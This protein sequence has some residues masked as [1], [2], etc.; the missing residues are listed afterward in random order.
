M[1]P[2]RP[3]M[4]NPSLER[5]YTAIWQS[6][7]PHEREWIDEI[8]GPFLN[9]QLTDGKHELVLDN[10]ILFEAFV[11]CHDLAYYERFR[12]KN[13]FLV[14]F[15]DE[16]FEGRYQEI[17]R[18]F[19][20]VF[21]CFWANVF[22]PKYVMQ[23]P[24]GY[25][26]G[27]SRRKR[28]IE[29]ATRRKYLWS[30]VGQLGKSSRP[31]MAK[32]LLVVEPHFLLATDQAPRRVFCHLDGKQRRLAPSECSEILLQSTFAPCPMGNV[33]LECYR[34]Y[35]ALE[36]GSIPIVEKR[37][38]LDYFREL[39]GEHP[40]PTVRSWRE[41]SD[42]I[43]RLLRSPAQ[44]DALQKRCL[45]WWDRYKWEY[46]E[47]VGEFLALRTAD[48]VPVSEPIMA[49]TY[50]MPGWRVIQLLRHHDAKAFARRVEKHVSR[51]FR[52]GE[53][54]VANRPGM[55]LD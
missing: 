20:G 10:A 40:V 24:V 51:L 31:D 7:D 14:H 49:K 53:L 17:Y 5:P 15:L 21:R 2:R 27:M 11:Y 29:P 23:L 8:F 44:I 16:N 45:D 1:L 9:E 6:P 38:T 48:P 52:K 36:C 25:C 19:R 37:W 50:F 54:R 18:N 41:A 35:E 55:S 3:Q 42:L 30:F 13:A 39:L 28:V 4:P 47:K 22:N 33:Q 43:R 26:S 12:G 34:L 46:R 32:S